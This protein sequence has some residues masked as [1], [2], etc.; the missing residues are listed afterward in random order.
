MNFRD[1]NI[2]IVKK[3]NRKRVSI[4]IERKEEVSIRVKRKKRVNVKVIK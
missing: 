2:K 1:L 4:R 3:M